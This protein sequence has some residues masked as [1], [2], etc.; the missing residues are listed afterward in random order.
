MYT[1]FRLPFILLELAL[2]GGAEAIK[3][4]LRLAAAPPAGDERPAH[5]SRD[6]DPVASF[7][8]SDDAAAR[9]D[10][11][12]PWVGYAEQPAAVIIARVRAADEATKAVVLLYERQHKKRRTVLQAAGG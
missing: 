5:V 6:A 7:G 12:P 11:Q 8:P 9:L 4:L 1:L 2:R 10:V 3:E